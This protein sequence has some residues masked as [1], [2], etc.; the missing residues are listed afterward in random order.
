MSLRK[1]GLASGALLLAGALALTACSS[2]G[3]SDS[4]SSGGTDG[5]GGTFSFGL[6][7]FQALTPSNCYDLYC[8]QV[9]KALFTGLFEFTTDDAGALVA[10]PT[11]LTK[12]VSTPDKG[13]TWE[14]QLNEGFT[15]TNGEKVT[16]QTFI[17][18]YNYAANGDNGQQLGFIFGPGSLD[19][20][21]YADVADGKTKEMSGLKAKDEYTLQ[22]T[23]NAAM[24]ESLFKNFITGPQV[25]PMPSEAF[26]DPEKYE[27]QPIGNGP[28]MMDGP[29]SNQ[30]L[31]VSKN[32]NYA[33]TAS[34]ADK[35]EF[36]I[37]AD[38]NAY[39][40]D[41][42]AN[43][44]DVTNNLPQNALATA[45]SV[46]GD[47]F[48][49]TPDGLQYSF[50]G[51]PANDDTF[52]EMDVRV[53]IAKSINWEEINQKLYYGTRQTATSF[54]PKTIPGGG[55]DVCG[56]KCSFDAAKAKQLIDD[57]G[58]VPGNTVRIPQLSNETGDVQKAI[59]NQ[60]QTNTG[61]TCTVEIFKDFGEM[62]DVTQ[63][64]KAPAGTLVGSGWVAD[65]PTIQNM[66]YFFFTSDSPGN[67]AQYKNPEFDKL[68]QEGVQAT[69]EATQ[70]AKWQEAEKVL[71]EDF[72][73][74][75]YQFRNQV[76]GYST[77]VSN[78]AISP[79]GLVDLDVITV[80]S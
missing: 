36:K 42:Q 14:I 41:L 38:S 24:T 19:V 74:W 11:E 55:E 22:I 2:G 47:R 35:I 49:N 72:P 69:D 66:I 53:G 30:G 62:L 27:K 40:A 4:S 43:T 26:K 79:D 1:R 71:Y 54:A 59:C 37:Y 44:L 5:T 46:L 18:T 77:N 9:N 6:E 51:F 64:G 61:V 76:G 68:L 23:L 16:A 60:I 20:E 56:D 21:G 28:Y 33:G 13:K 70:I 78:V 17:D 80:N 45:S 39:W 12:A 50:F 73:A 10:T 63:A 29:Y 3:S 75:A 57:A 32:P 67:V 58:G 34:S 15:F 8:A 48:I 65:N 31:T 52:K 7:K 25:L